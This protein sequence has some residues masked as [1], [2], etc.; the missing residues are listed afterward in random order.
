MYQLNLHYSVNCNRQALLHL[1]FSG[2][3]I[4]IYFRT[5]YSHPGKSTPSFSGDGCTYI[6]MLKRSFYCDEKK[7]INIFIN[8]AFNVL[9]LKHFLHSDEL[10]LFTFNRRPYKSSRD[11]V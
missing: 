9:N 7:F 10:T 11:S 1:H 2:T 5:I 4:I 8:F 6:Q 3:A